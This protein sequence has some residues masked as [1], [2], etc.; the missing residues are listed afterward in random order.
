MKAQSTPRHRTH[1]FAVGVR[2]DKA[3]LSSGCKPHPATAPAGSSRSSHGGNEVAEAFGERVTIYGDGAL[4]QPAV[5]SCEK[6]G[7]S[8]ELTRVVPG[9]GTLPELLLFRCTRCGQV[10][11]QKGRLS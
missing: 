6:C 10:T 11:K 3:A 9:L 8:T 1:E 2:R 4:N 7:G 5:P